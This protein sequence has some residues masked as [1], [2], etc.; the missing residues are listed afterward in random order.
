MNEAPL[1][2]TDVMAAAGAAAAA[3]ESA[4]TQFPAAPANESDLVDLP[5]GLVHGEHVYR[6]AK[7]KELNGGDEEKIS[8]ALMSGNMFHFFSTVL[9]C[10]VE[11]IG[12]L[13]ADETRKLLPQLLIGDREA[14]L[15][16]IRCMTY[17]DTV[18]V[19]DWKCPECGEPVNIT[20]S[21][22]DDVKVRK[23]ADPQKETYFDVPLR[24]GGHATVRLPNGEDQA[25]VA[26]KA[27]DRNLAERNT[28]LLQRCVHE[29]D[30]GNGNKIMI[31]GFPSYV[32]Q[33]GIKDRRA[34]IAAIV[35]RQPGPL[36]NEIKFNHLSC[37]NEVTLGL[38]LA[39]LFLG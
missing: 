17:D 33:M 3:F 24:H 19:V 23:L 25:A 18:D 21:L 31:A 29:V 13:S 35:D 7:V 9:E 4:K 39:D 22:H 1:S 28:I 12:D 6:T 14:L 15:L 11:T 2:S 38:N 30:Q 32:L 34:I 16:G 36:Y 27:A 5:G 37:G 20:L 8:R 26:E 10:G